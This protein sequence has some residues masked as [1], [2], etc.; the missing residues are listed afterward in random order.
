MFWGLPGIKLFI[1]S[2]KGGMGQ[3]QAMREGCLELEAVPQV[4]E[5]DFCLGAGSE[6]NC[7]MSCL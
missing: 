4:L 3:E 1:S 6:E 2:D 7:L 5:R